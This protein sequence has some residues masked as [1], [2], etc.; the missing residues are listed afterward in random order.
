LKGRGEALWRE[1]VLLTTRTFLSPRAL[2][3]GIKR[4]IK[5]NVDGGIE[6]L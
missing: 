3:M 2:N 1:E 6:S 5:L 4:I